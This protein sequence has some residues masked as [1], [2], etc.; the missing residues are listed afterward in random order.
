VS[1]VAFMLSRYPI[2]TKYK[3]P[4]CTRKTCSLDCVKLHKELD[5]CSGIRDKTAYVPRSQYN[6][7]HLQSGKANSSDYQFLEE[8]SAELDGLERKIPNGSTK[9]NFLKKQ[10][11]KRGIELQLLPVGMTRQSTNRTVYQ[12]RQNRF[13][14][15]I[16][17]KFLDRS[18]TQHK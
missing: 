18:Y 13:L 1:N 3:C 6:I 4:K 15:T 12:S 9:R 8:V 7:N 17:W 2:L 16:E 14:W 11:S 10:A 5:K